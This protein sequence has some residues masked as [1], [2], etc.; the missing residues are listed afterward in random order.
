MNADRKAA[1]LCNDLDNIV[2]RIEDLPADEG[3][4]KAQTLVEEAREI[5][6]KTRVRR[7]HAD[8]AERLG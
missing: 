8:M 4:T 1:I 5:I 3:Y 6:E 7:H 2:H